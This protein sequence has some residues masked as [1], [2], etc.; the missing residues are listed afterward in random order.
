MLAIKIALFVSLFAGAMLG[1]FVGKFLD[2][3]NCRTR[4]AQFPGWKFVGYLNSE[5]VSG[6]GALAGLAIGLPIYFGDLGWRVLLSFEV[7]LLA[8]AGAF[9][10][11]FMKPQIRWNDD[12]IVS[13][14]LFGRERSMA[15]ED[16][17]SA[18]AP[19]F[20]SRIFISDH[21]GTEFSF[22]GSV[23]GAGPLYLALQD[24]LGSAF[25]GRSGYLD[26][27]LGR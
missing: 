4:R 11:S 3:R 9:Y 6:V 23:H 2:T 12:L 7:G 17:A 21:F 26:R 20:S 5:I 10:W 24:Q 14:D 19:K 27:R 1:M 18:R 15:R 16:V 25:V 8:F 22:K 13:R